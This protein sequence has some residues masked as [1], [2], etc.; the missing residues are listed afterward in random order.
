MTQTKHIWIF[1]TLA[2]LITLSSAYYQRKTGPSHP[3]QIEQEI[4]GTTYNLKFIRGYSGND[5][6]K[7][8]LSIPDTSI[9]G[10]LHYRFYPVMKDSSW[11]TS[12]LTREGGHLI[13]TLPHQPPAGKLQYYV[14]LTKGS[15]TASVAAQKPIKIRFTGSVPPWVLIPH[16]LTM[17]IAM[18]FSNLSGL[19]ALFNIQ[20]FRTYAFWTLGL[21]MIGG[22]FLGPVVQNFA[23][24]EFWTGFPFGK[25]LTDNKTLLGVVGW[26]V[27]V[28]GNIKKERPHLVIAAS[29]LMLVVYLIPHSA[30]GS[31]L[32]R[33]TG[34]ITTGFIPLFFP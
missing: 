13:A 3:K 26:L 2:I 25:D 30:G 10:T 4:W 11:H 12:D 20:S 6:C 8:R 18:L 16:I 15:E 29:L 9:T 23:F 24:G 21:I 7:V 27:A 19:L 31:E 17:F 5:D 28:V 14:S 34:Q 33:T 32:D 1:W 22:M